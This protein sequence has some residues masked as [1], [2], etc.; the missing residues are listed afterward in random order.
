MGIRKLQQHR[1]VTGAFVLALYLLMLSGVASR[2][3]GS[4]VVGSVVPDQAVVELLPSASITKINADYGTTTHRR[5]PNSSVYLL[6]LPAGSSVKATVRRMSADQR[7][8]YAEPNFVVYPPEGGARHRAFGMSDAEPSPQENAASALNLSIAHNISQGKGVTVAVL[9][10][11]AQLGHP[12]LRD[13]FEG[14]VSYDFVDEDGNPSDSPV[15]ADDD[16]NGFEDELLGHGTHVAG[17]VDLVAPKAKIMPLRVLDTEGYGE[18]FTIARAVSYAA[19][20]GSH[21]INLSLGTPSRSRLLRN[22]IKDAIK[23]GVLVAAAAGNSNSST[24]YY[25][26]AG[27]GGAASADGLVAVSSVS[28]YE[29]KSDFANYGSWVD[30]AAPGEDIRSAFP[31][32]K[33]AYWSGTS[34]ATPFV[35]GQAA[36]VHAVYGSLRPAGVEGKIRCSARPL[37]ATDPVYGTKLGA[38]HTD[39]GASLTPGACD[40]TAPPWTTITAG[41]WG[42]TNNASATFAFAS[43]K[44]D[45]SFECKLDDAPFGACTSKMTLT[46]RDGQHTFEVRATDATGNTDSTPAI[47][48]WSVDTTAPNAPIIDSPADNSRNNT[49]DITV[50]GTAEAGST[51]ELFKGGTS[52]G[53]DEASPDGAWSIQLNGVPNGEHTYTATAKDKAGNTSD[54]SAEVRI[55][56]DTVAPS[57]SLTAPADGATV[58]G[59]VSLSSD[60]AD[61]VEVERIDFLVDGSV[62]GTD[63]SAPYGFDWNTTDVPDGARTIAARAHDAAGNQTTSAAHTVVVDNTAPAAPSKPELVASSDS[64]SENTDHR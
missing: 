57:V 3:Q 36:L 9:D 40:T 54:A 26:A 56:V 44:A 17:I 7:L 63:A 38:G 16:G 25:P 15:G 22:V 12:A 50:S 33:Y 29:Q 43:S 52:R 60:A 49:G 6:K 14:V 37:I 1:V 34:M 61:N 24:P 23:D 21:V 20:N 46:L 45:S 48:T 2:A 62:V 19:R 28:M 35:S 18:N 27:S 13:N 11:G 42:L 41:P 4:S 55:I 8:L 32:S 64:G 5:L 39:V 53:T 10:T 31:V 30:N 59:T 47:R 58:R 51:V